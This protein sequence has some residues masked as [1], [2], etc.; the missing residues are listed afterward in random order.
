MPLFSFKLQGHELKYMKQY[1][2][3]MHFDFKVCSGSLQK[4]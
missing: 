3:C 4:T 2:D 1:E